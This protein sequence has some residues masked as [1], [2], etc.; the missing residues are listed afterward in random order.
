M[1]RGKIKQ[2]Q[3]RS[4]HSIV[5]ERVTFLGNQGGTAEVDEAGKEASEPE[6]DNFQ[7]NANNPVERDLMQQLEKAKAKIQGAKKEAPAK[8]EQ[9]KPAVQ[10]AAEF[11][12]QPPF[13][14]DLPF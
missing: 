12:D 9:A 13:K 8:D 3:T 2:S 7:L 1:I 14:D 5:A 6:P 4:K 10:P 11:V